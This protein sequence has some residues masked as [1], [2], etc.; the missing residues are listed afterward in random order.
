MK[1]RVKKPFR[2]CREG[3]PVP[4][5]FDKGDI[6]EGR[7][8]EVAVREKWATEIKPKPAADSAADAKS[9]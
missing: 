3:N 7:M 4:E 8:A 2:G 1:A 5:Q 9:D 6:V